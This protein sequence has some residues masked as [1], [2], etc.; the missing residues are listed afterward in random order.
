MGR[1]FLV[2]YLVVTQLREIGNNK[3]LR[4]IKQIQTKLRTNQS[5]PK[6]RWSLNSFSVDLA[7]HLKLA[8]GLVA[9]AIVTLDFAWHSLAPACTLYSLNLHQK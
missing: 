9:I 7:T 5:S 8:K 6:L 2:Q 4:N 3:T 1:L